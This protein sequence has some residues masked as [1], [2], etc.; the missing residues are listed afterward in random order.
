[1]GFKRVIVP[2]RRKKEEGIPQGLEVIEVRT[3]RAALEKA[4][5]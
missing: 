3:I 4:F 1:L 5:L 2:G